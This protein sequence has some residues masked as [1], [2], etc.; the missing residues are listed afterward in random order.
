[1]KP[2]FFATPARFRAW[3]ARNHARARELWVGFYKK[4]S[5]R[6]SITWPESVGEALCFGW[7]DG[8][9]RSVD[10]DS[11]AIRFTPRKPD[12]TWSAIN[13]KRASELARQGRMSPAGLA[14]FRKRTAEN[15]AVHS[16]EQRRAAKLE[17]AQERRFRA[18]AKAW[19]FFQAQAPWYRRTAT[20]WVVSAKR[21]ETRDRRL[22]TLIADSARGRAVP[23]LGRTPSRQAPPR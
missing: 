17:A 15:T 11:Y 7:I 9:R 1:M 19:T 5:G 21:E 6:P 18:N 22:A 10:G 14:A 20:W 4:A 13:V 12:S 2:R 16:F 3:L 8:L 23:P